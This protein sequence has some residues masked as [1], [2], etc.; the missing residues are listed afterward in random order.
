MDVQTRLRTNPATIQD[1]LDR[2]DHDT[3]PPR[4][5]D[6]RLSPRVPFRA[7]DVVLELSSGSSRA[8]RHAAA[9]RNLS[10]EGIGLLT[11]RFAYPG[12]RC[13]VAFADSSET[14]PRLTGQVRRCR[15]V[16]GSGTLYEIGIEFDRPV[17]VTH[18]T[19]AQPADSTD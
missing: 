2:L 10:R 17:D 19:T 3:K 15:Y 8:T 4:G 12:T 7:T 11:S 14:M 5:L 18:L 6:V 1:W 16:V 13:R 9:G